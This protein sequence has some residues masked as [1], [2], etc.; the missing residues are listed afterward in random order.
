VSVRLLDFGLAQLEEAD[1]L[2]A[3]GDVPGTLAYI[4]PERLD[5]HE[6]TGAADVWGVGVLLWEALA[7]YHPFWSA[8]PVELARR[9]GAG[10][11]PIAKARPDLPAS[12]ARAVDRALASDPRRRP[13][14]KQLETELRA[15]REEAAAR[16]SRRPTVSRYVVLERAGHAGLAAAFTALAASL[17]TFYPP[18]WTLA[19]AIAA[20]LASFLHPRAGLGVALAVP[21]LPLGDVSLGLAVVYGVV[22]L[23]WAGAAWRDPRHGLLVAAGPLFTFVG[24]LA[25]V[26]LVAER[27]PGAVR[28]ALHAGAAVLLAALVAGL[29]GSSLPFTGDAPP[30]GLGIAGSDD[31]VAVAGALWRALAGQPAIAIEAMVLALTA[32]TLPYARARGLVGASVL[33]AAFLTAALAGPPVFGAGPVSF[34][35]VLLGAGGLALALALPSLARRHRR[36]RDDGRA[37]ESV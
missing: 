10:A 31:P 8:S 20:A 37:G 7:G 21:V 13:S 33:P 28:R 23:A 18:S 6:A 26:P 32:A 1:T 35:P 25:L 14:P 24:A 4:A 9:I 16:R 2:T 34:V 27:A 5:G 3:A 15:S 12:L 29:H 19:L 22:A 17:L 36:L 30:L 11:P